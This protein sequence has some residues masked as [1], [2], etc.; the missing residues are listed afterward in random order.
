MH[1]ALQPD[2]RYHVFARLASRKVMIPDEDDS[3][4]GEAVHAADPQL[5]VGA[6]AGQGGHVHKEVLGL[7]E[8][9][10]GG[11][12]Q[13]SAHMGIGVLPLVPVAGRGAK[14]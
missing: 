4:Q 9:A 11:L 2:I 12:A 3:L 5:V 1:V 7:G 13:R 14:R 8:G 10:G 6:Q